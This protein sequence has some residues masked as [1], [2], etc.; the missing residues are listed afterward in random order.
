MI[1]VKTRSL[2]IVLRGLPSRELAWQTVVDE[3][4]VLSMAQYRD[5]RI[6]ASLDVGRPPTRMAY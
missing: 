4:T 3:P 2:P 5:G 1:R 6:V